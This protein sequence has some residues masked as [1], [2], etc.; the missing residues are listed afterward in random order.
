M[1]GIGASR[2]FQPEP[3]REKSGQEADPFLAFNSE[4]TEALVPPTPPPP[5][6]F[7]QPPR[8][9]PVRE[10]LIRETLPQTLPQSYKVDPPVNLAPITIGL[11]IGLAGIATAGVLYFQLGRQQAK[12][13]RSARTSAATPAVIQT[14]GTL[15]VSSRPEGAR[16]LVDGQLHG[17]TPL[18]VTLPLGSHEIELQNGN[19]SRKLPLTIAGGETVSQVI[20]LEPL[21]QGYVA[22]RTPLSFRISEGGKQIGTTGSGRLTLSAGRHELELA[23]TTLDYRTRVT[24]YITPGQTVT[25]SVEVPHGTVSINALPWAS[26]WLDGQAMG[27]TPLGNIKVPIGSHEIVWRHP[28]LGERKRVVQ[29]TTKTPVRVGLD[30]R[31]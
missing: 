6:A 22:I 3:R 5:P 17:A 7:V 13:S 15:S 26:V 16:V 11:C 4:A 10:P 28:T 1:A 14:H 8:A 29:V 21:S 12:T 24:V 20:D 30:F 27:M 19:A 31:Q 25:T 18:T 2:I 23:S 9:E